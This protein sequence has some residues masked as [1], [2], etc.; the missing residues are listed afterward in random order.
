VTKNAD[1][2]YD[3]TSGDTTSAKAWHVYAAPHDIDMD[4]SSVKNAVFNEILRQIKA[5]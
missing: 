1:G 2:S 3:I 5:I 4:L